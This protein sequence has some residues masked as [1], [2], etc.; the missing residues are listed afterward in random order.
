MGCIRV[1]QGQTLV[2]VHGFLTVYSSDEIL[3]ITA[4]CHK[5]LKQA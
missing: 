1:G 4:E 5:Q 2:L 3:I